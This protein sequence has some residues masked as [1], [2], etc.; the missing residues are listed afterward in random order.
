MASFT[1]VGDSVELSLPEKGEDILVSLSGTYN[2]VIELQREIAPG[3]W[4]EAIRTYSTANATVADYYTT[5]NFGEKLR[6]IVTTDTS[7]TCTATLTDETD[8][9][10]EQ[11]KNGIVKTFQSGVQA[12]KRTVSLTAATYSAAEM[13]EFA[14]CL[15]VLNLAAGIDITLPDATGSGDVYEF[16]VGIATTDAY[17][18]DAFASTTSGDIN[19]VIVGVDAPGDEF[20]WGAIGTENA[21]ILGGTAQATGGSV[22]DRVTLTDILAAKWAASGFINQGGTEATPFATNS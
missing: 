21:V 6:L 16:I 11:G 20:T 7:G 2:M 19:G 10:L 12:R 8:K 14:N 1:G 18:L 13:K 5:Q 17:Q 3:L 4:S 15:C 9:L 22:G